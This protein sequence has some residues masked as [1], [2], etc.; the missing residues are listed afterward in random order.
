M[1]L[2]VKAFAKYWTECHVIIRNRVSLSMGSRGVA[3]GAS[4]L[5]LALSRDLN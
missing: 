1:F 3:A 5:S 4:R 2:N